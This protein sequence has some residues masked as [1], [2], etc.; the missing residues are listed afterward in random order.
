MT[1]SSDTGSTIIPCLRYRDARAAIAWLERAFGFRAQAV[2]AEGDLVYHAQ[3]VYGTGMIML[4][5]VDNGSEWGK[6]MVQPDEIDGRETQSACVIVTDP[7]AHYARAV[8]AGAELVIDIADQD[9]GGRGY[10]CRDLE[11]HLWWFG[12]YDPWREA[13]L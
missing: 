11:G 4:G 12:S 5:S 8:A 10:A 13:G 9:Y 6:R 7:D 1:A 3:L 2:H